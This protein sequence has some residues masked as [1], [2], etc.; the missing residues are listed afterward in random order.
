M[1][2][3]IHSDKLLKDIRAEFS[4]RFPFLKLEFYDHPHQVGE[5]NSGATQLNPDLPV[6]NAGKQVS[7]FDWHVTGLTT[8][9]ELEQT[10]QEKL[11]IGVQVFRRSGGLW[12][13]TMKTDHL[14]LS[15]Q[16]VH[17]HESTLPV[18]GETEAADYREQE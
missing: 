2:I 11:G 14:T 1:D 6:R 15:E 13:Q 17:G 3:H 5:G 12:L 9:A 16:N 4:T 10:F 8:V 18:S 7:D